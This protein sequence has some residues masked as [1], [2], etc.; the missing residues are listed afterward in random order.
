MIWVGLI[1]M[2]IVEILMIKKSDE[3]QR[4]IW[5]GNL[6]FTLIVAGFAFLIFLFR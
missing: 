1:I 4:R 2:M 3:Y 6:I 5:I